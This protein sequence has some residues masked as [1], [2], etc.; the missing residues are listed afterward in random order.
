MLQTDKGFCKY[1]IFPVAFWIK[2]DSIL[3]F[4]IGSLFCDKAGQVEMVKDG[5]RG[6]VYDRR[7]RNGPSVTNRDCTSIPEQQSFFFF[8]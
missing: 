4:K 8:F 1:W 6:I 7:W 3:M 2:M 5:Y